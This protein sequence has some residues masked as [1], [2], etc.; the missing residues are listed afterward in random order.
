MNIY[1]LFCRNLID[2][3]NCL[4]F[5]ISKGK[6]D[7]LKK[8]RQLGTP[9]AA[10]ADRSLNRRNLDLAMQEWARIHRDEIGKRCT[11]NVLY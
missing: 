3:K 4:C 1:L 2:I 7:T 5:H 9:V 10:A 8:M 11:G 6:R